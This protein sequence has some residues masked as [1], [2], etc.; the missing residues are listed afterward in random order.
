M[1]ASLTTKPAM[2]DRKDMEEEYGNLEKGN[3]GRGESKGEQQKVL[4]HINRE[5]G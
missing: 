3:G 5:D 1:L 2:K 4:V